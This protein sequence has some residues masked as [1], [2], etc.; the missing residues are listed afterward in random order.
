MRRRTTSV[1]APAKRHGQKS[2]R[3]PLV[4]Q[5]S[6]W[7]RTVRRKR[8]MSTSALAKRMNCRVQ[9]IAALEK[10][11]DNQILELLMLVRLFAAMGYELSF[12]FVRANRISSE[13]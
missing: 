4:A 8:Q 11:E 13:R 1:V 10:G 9:K 12:R 2:L 7:L 3:N 5:L 6:Q